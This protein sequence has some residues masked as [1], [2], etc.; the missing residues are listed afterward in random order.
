[1]AD[2]VE[3][4]VEVGSKRAFVAALDWP[5]WCRPGKGEDAAIEAFVA[6]GD[7]YK[8]TIGTAARGLRVP[9]DAS[10]LHV[11]E[12]V[13]GD[14]TT[15]F[16]APSKEVAADERPLDDVELRRQEKLLQACWTAFDEGA[17]AAVGVELRKGPRGG[18][19]DLDK[20]VEHVREADGGYLHALG[21]RRP[22][23]EGDDPDALMAE[24]RG[25][26]LATF[27][28]RA[29]GEPTERTPRSGKLWSPRF[30]VRR[31]AWHA[32]DHTWEIEDRSA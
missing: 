14:A 23:A 20:I 19:R 16:G 3:V 11:V 7:R 4:Y 29:R 32:I 28:S 17:G 2:R 15:D 27:R 5:G 31:S 18:G 21:G 6:A 8:R 25:A 24:L 30:L 1:M 10:E 12:R 13:P 26:I 22:K 9:R